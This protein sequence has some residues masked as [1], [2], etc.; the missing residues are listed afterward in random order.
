MQLHVFRGGT[1][2]DAASGVSHVFFF[3]CGVYECLSFFHVFSIQTFFSLKYRPF[4][5]ISC[6]PRPC[7]SALSKPHVSA[8]IS[9]WNC[10]WQ[11]RTFLCA[12]CN[13]S[14]GYIMCVQTPCNKWTR[15]TNI[16][17]FAQK[18]KKSFI[19]SNN[20]ILLFKL[21]FFNLKK[22]FLFFVIYLQ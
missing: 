3:F 2:G 18:K 8:D 22:Y 15:T 13:N 16:K 5:C 6:P 19:K 12:L 17:Y 21:Y 11:S 4:N 1:N 10:M 9:K 20:H 14:R 7:G